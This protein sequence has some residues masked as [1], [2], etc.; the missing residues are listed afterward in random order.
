MMFIA[1]YKPNAMVVADYFLSYIMRLSGL[2]NPES[3]GN[4][5]RFRCLCGLR[6]GFLAARLL[7]M[8]V[9]IPP[10]AWKSVSRECCVLSGRDLCVGLI[11]RPE[12]FYRL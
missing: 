11:T 4:F 2:R 8:R 7:G 3:E 12:E 10:E 1:D 6:R 5:G 9:R